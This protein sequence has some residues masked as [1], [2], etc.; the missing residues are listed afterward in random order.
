M[1]P[2]R[3]F[4]VTPGVIPALEDA[5]IVVRSEG[6][7]WKVSDIERAQ[8][9]V[10]SYSPIKYAVETRLA[11]AA[12]ARW[13]TETG[14]IVSNGLRVHTD[15]DSRAALIAEY[16]AAQNGLR[17]DGAI[18]KFADGVPRSMTNAEMISIAHTVMAH[19][20]K[21][22]ACEAL[23]HAKITA[24]GLTWQEVWAIDV[25]VGS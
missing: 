6:G 21:C 3:D 18:Y 17:T 11:D 5:G 2:Y 16:V 9:I 1:T 10:S 7:V 13:R 24:P 15:R 19:V 22:F 14:G 4:V 25:S 8:K 12:D 23:L 20:Q